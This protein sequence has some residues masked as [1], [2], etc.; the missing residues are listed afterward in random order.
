MFKIITID[1][2]QTSKFNNAISFCEEKMGYEGE[3]WELVK[4]AIHLKN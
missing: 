3:V 1:F 2:Y 4:K